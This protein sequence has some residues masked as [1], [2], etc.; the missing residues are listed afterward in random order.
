MGTLEGSPGAPLPRATT[1]AARVD[2]LL[3]GAARGVW[4]LHQAK[5]ELLAAL[6]A[7]AVLDP[8]D[9]AALPPLA[10]AGLGTVLLAK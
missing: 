1:L 8:D 4:T 10:R 9:R 7:V 3:Q 5:E 2:V 6:L